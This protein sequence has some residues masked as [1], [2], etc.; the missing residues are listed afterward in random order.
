MMSS[1]P[2]KI[3]LRTYLEIY[4]SIRKDPTPPGRIIQ[5]KNRDL[6]QDED[7]REIEKWESWHGEDY[8]DFE[9]ES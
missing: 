5:P 6:A 4:K 9:D 3:R 7:E 8:E 2:K 1:K